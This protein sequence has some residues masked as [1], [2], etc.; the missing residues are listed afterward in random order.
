[1]F[2]SDLEL[3]LVELPAGIGVV[4]TLLVRLVG[5]SGLEGWGET[6]PVWHAG[7]LPARRNSLLAALAGR[8][9]HAVEAFLGDNRLADPV[10]VYPEHPIAQWSLRQW[11]PIPHRGC[12][13]HQV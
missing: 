6:R 11:R 9:M 1:M 12:R 5:E 7:E 2:L 3:F 13:E 8:E 4:R 10:V